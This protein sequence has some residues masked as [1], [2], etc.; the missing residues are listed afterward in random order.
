MLKKLLYD[1]KTNKKLYP[2]LKIINGRIVI[3]CNNCSKIIHNNITP[4]R[5]KRYAENI[6]CY[7]CITKLLFKIFKK[8]ESK[9]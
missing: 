2:R 6:F 4:E 7:E 5:L 1:P 9:K 8:N 3:I